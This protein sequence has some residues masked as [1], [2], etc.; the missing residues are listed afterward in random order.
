MDTEMHSTPTPTMRSDITVP[1]FG[2]TPTAA[3]RTSA[4]TAPSTTARSGTRESASVPSTTEAPYRIRCPL[5]RHPHKL[6]HCGL[7]K[8]MTPHN[9]SKLPRRIGI[10]TIVWHIPTRLRNATPE[11]CAKCVAGSI[12]RCFTVHRGERSVGS[13]PHESVAQTDRSKPI[14]C[15]VAEERHPDLTTVHGVSKTSHLLGVGRTI[16]ARPDSATMW[17]R[18]NSYHDC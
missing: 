15:H 9:A 11:L 17:Q 3:P 13:L 7:F 5:C 18:C 16:G 6:Q 12:T 1:R 8:G 4:A 2:V 10:V 14:A